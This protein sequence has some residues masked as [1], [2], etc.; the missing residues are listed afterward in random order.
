MKVE[1]IKPWSQIKCKLDLQN[2]VQSF[3]KLEKIR[4]GKKQDTLYLARASSYEVLKY[5]QENYMYSNYHPIVC[6]AVDGTML[7]SLKLQNML[8]EGYKSVCFANKDRM[9]RKAWLGEKALFNAL[10]IKVYFSSRS[11]ATM[12]KCTPKMPKLEKKLRDYVLVDSNLGIGKK[13][14]KVAF[15]PANAL[16]VEVSGFK[17]RE[18]FL[19][20]HFIL[21]AALEGISQ[22]VRCVIE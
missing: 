5:W 12:S 18:G 2:I 17:K 3:S 15:V 11:P 22:P 13:V 10:G 9:S 16:S 8:L 4:Q 1:F 19:L 6:S 21:L 20:D 7:Y 14:G